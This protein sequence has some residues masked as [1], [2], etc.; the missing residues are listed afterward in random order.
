MA[1][2]TNYATLRYGGVTVTSNTVT[3]VLPDALTLTK[4]AVAEDY[5]PGDVVS[6]LV[7]L[8]NPGT[9]DLT[10]L[11]VTDD[12]GA[13]A[14]GQGTVYPLAYTPGSLRLLV[15]GLPQAAPAVAPGP[16]L[17]VTGLTVPAGGTAVLAYEAALTAYA[18][19]AE[20]S[21]ITNTATVTG[22]TAPLTASATI[23]PEV[24]PSLRITKDLT[25]ALVREDGTVTY[26]F[27]IENVGNAPADAASAVVLEDLFQP[28]LTGLTVTGDGTPWTS[29]VEYTYTEGLFT[30]LPGTLTLP[31]AAYVQAPDGTWAMTP[32]RTVVTVTGN[33]G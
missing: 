33:I 25:P 15:N 26:T 8:V 30:T 3:G 27:T 19:L 12:L 2:F 1:T 18:P 32:G 4:T 17:V 22:L 21:S 23:T 31:A 5:A 11:T 16:P 9:T 20:G 10:G 24:G 6:Y 28:A 13:C 29:G 14:F 7:S